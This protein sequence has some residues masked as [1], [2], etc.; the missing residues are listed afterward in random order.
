MNRVL[1]LLDQIIELAEEQE[2]ALNQANIALHRASRTVGE[3]SVLFHLKALRELIV[4]E[5]LSSGPIK[6]GNKSFDIAI[7]TNHQE[8]F[9]QGYDDAL[10]GKTTRACPYTDGPPK[11][12]WLEGWN[13]GS[14]S[15]TM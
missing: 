1:E 8:Y 15:M 7:G 13:A 14:Y 2:K 3:S 12:W 10:L 9:Q 6:L 11:E 5:T 4:K